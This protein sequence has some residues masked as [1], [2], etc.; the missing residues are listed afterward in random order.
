VRREK[1]YHTAHRT[2]QG[3]GAGIRRTLH[4]F[5]QICIGERESWSGS[6]SSNEVGYERLR[7]YVDFCGVGRCDEINV[8][9]SLSSLTDVLDVL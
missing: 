1:S 3:D 5:G 9:F 4:D 2:L 6:E 8:D 7:V